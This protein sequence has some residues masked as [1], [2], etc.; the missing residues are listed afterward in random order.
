MNQYKKKQGKLIN[1]EIFSNKVR[2]KLIAVIMIAMI[3]PLI[4]LGYLAY[5]T[6]FD[7]LQDKLSISTQQTVE[8]VNKALTRFLEGIEYQVN[9]LAANSSF[10]RLENEENVVSGASAENQTAKE[11][12]K[13]TK[14]SNENIRNVF[15]GTSDGQMYIYPQDT[16]QRSFDPKTR[17]WYTKAVKNIGQVIWTEPYVDAN[18]QKVILTAAKAVEKNGKIIGVAAI[19]INLESLSNALSDRIIGREGYLF[20]ADKNGMVIAH[21]DHQ[22]IATD[23]PTTQTFWETVKNNEEGFSKYTFDGKEK[24]LSFDTNEKIGWKL[25]ACMELNELLRDTNVIKRFM[26]YAI[27][28]GCILAIIVAFSIASSISK[29]LNQLRKTFSLAASGDLT[30]K[31][32]IKSKDEFGDIGNNF[33]E[34][35][36]NI[37][38]LINDIKKSFL[39]V[40]ETSDALSSITKQTA[41]AADEVA[42]TIEE[43]AKSANEQAQD[44]EKSTLKIS[45]LAEKIEMVTAN[46]QHM[47]EISYQ[48]N[49]LSDK[50]I[51][52]IEM[53]SKKSEE[54]SAASSKVNEIVG[55]VNKRAGEIGKITNV[56]AQIAEQTNLLALNAAIEAARAGDQGRGFAVVAEEVRQ[57]AEQSADATN[58]IRD[59]ILAIQNQSKTAVD[60]I[61]AANLVAKDEARVVKDTKKIFQDILQEIQIFIVKVKEVKTYTDDMMQHKEEMVDI[62][63][64]I[65]AVSQQTSAATQEVSGAT[66][67][68]LAT[69]EEIAAYSQDLKKLANVLE[70]AINQF[71]IN[72]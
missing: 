58:E 38:I 70:E 30:V 16:L 26:L 71:K 25:M 62:I 41:A 52:T 31:T 20:V 60:F 19:D 11:L 66:E 2:N 51:E 46:T 33:E 22:L 45:E 17:P 55:K 28:L 37:S 72:G 53:L 57:L 27:L 64:N 68:Q 63:S 32:E 65:S 8:E 6:S 36:Q 59:L 7:I 21:P 12:L 49:T 18:S 14:E 3:I 35:L 69:V 29:P 40:L 5:K 43:I 34:M 24:F 67:E 39:T 9:V 15:F 4:L 50:G 42:S 47:E 54:N 48:A 56:I 13:T 61:E 23:T 44:T 10:Q 1:K